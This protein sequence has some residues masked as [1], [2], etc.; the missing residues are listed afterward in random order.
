[1]WKN[2]KFYNG[3]SVLPYDGGTYIQAPFEDSTKEIYEEMMKTLSEI[4][5]SK[6]VELE[7]NTDLSGELACA[8]GTCEIDVDLKNLNGNGVIKEKEVSETQI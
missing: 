1:M 4:D 2:R 8:G 5:L 3:L 7:D 6:V